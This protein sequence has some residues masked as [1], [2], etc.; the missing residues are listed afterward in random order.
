[1]S[2]DPNMREVS[3]EEGKSLTFFLYREALAM[4]MAL[5]RLGFGAKEAERVFAG[6][7]RDL[8]RTVQRETYQTPGR[9]EKI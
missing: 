6:N 2:A 5:L 1:V 4:K 3:E 9:W 8:L 7:A